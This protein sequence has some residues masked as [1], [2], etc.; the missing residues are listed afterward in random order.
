MITVT[1]MTR[2][3]VWTG[4][5]CAGGTRVCVIPD[6]D[7]C[8][9]SL[10]LAGDDRLTVTLPLTSAAR[11]ELTAGRVLRVVQDAATFD[12]WFLS[13][14]AAHVDDARV[15]VNALAPENA[16]ARAALVG[17]VDGLGVVRYDVEAV[18]LTPLQHLNGLLVPWLVAQ[19]ITWVTV[20]VV[21]P[22]APVDLS[23]QWEGAIAVARKI[24]SLSQSEFQFR[25]V[26]TASYAIDIL[27]K[28]G[29]AAPTA[30]F[31]RRKNIEDLGVTR[32]VVEQVTRVF[33]RGSQQ[34]GEYATMGEAEWQVTN[35][36]GGGTVISLADPIGGP[37]PIQF[38]DQL[39]DTYVWRSAGTHARV[40]DSDATAQT[41]TLAGA[42]GLAIGEIV[43]FRRDAGGTQLT[44]LDSPVDIAASG[45]APSGVVVGVLDV[46][47]VPAT[48]NIISNP[49]ARLWPG[50]LPSGWQLVGVPQI[51]KQLAA[52]YVQTA[53]VSIK[54]TAANDGIGVASPAALVFPAADRPYFSGFMSLWVV[55][56]S[57][58]VE[59]VALMADG[60]AIILPPAPNVATSTLVGQW[61]NLGISGEDFATLGVVTA[62]LRAVQDGEDA[63]VF[64][65]DAAQLTQTPSQQPFIEGSGGTRLWQAANERLRTYGAP[66]V[67]YESQVLDRARLDPA[68]YGDDSALV[69]GGNARVTDDRVLGAPVTTRVVAIER[70]YLNEGVGGFT[71][72]NKPEDLSGAS[73]RPRAVPRVPSVTPLVIDTH[74]REILSVEP[75]ESADGKQ[76]TYV[77]TCGA[78]VAHLYVHH[79][80]WREGTVGKIYDFSQ[81]QSLEDDPQL[82]IVPPDPADG[83]FR[84]TIDHPV[85]GF[86]VP[87]LMVPR[88]GLPSLAF[89]TDVFKDTLDPAPPS[90]NAKIHP[91][92]VGALASLSIDI[93][94]G[95]SDAD[96]TGVLVDVIEDALTTSTTIL[97][98][99]VTV[100]GTIDNLS[101]PALG[102][103]ALPPGKDSLA[104]R[105]R[106]TDVSG[107]PWW[108]GPASANRDPLPNGTPAVKNYRAAPAIVCPFDPDTDQIRYTAHDGR[109]KTYNGAA[110]LASGSPITYTVGNVLDDAST[111]QALAVDE[112]R[113]AAK[114]EYQGGGTWVEMWRGDLH[115]QPS[116][117]PTADIRTEK[118][119]DADAEN[120]FIRPDTQV[121]EKLFV[122]YREG[123]TDTALE[124]IAC[125]SAGDPTPLQVVA[126]T[127]LGPSN[128]FRRVDGVGSP[129]AKLSSI[130]LTRDQLE[131]HG[132][133]IE[134]VDS[135]I[136]SPWLDVVLSLKQQPWN[137]SLGLV[138]DPSNRE[139]S[140]I[141]VAGAHTG[142]AFFEFADNEALSAPSTASG[143]VA[144]GNTLIKKITLSA[145]QLGKKWWVGVTPLSGA[146]LSGLPGAKQKASVVVPAIFGDPKVTVTETPTTAT[147]TVQIDDPGGY[148][149]STWTNGVITTALSLEIRKLGVV[150]TEAP[151]SHTLVGT[152]HTWTKTFTLLD[153]VIG[154]KATLHL[155]DA[156]ALDIWESG[157]D[158]NKIS[159]VY[160]AAV[161][162]NGVTATVT[163]VFDTDTLIG[164][165][166]A[167]YRVDGGAWT[168]VTV[169]SSLVAQFNVTRTSAKQTVDIQ[170]KNAIDS[171]WGNQS[172]V[173]I[174]AYISDGPSLTVTPTPGDSSYSIAWSGVGT[175]T[176]SIDGGSYSTP[177]ASPITV[178]RDGHDHT[179]TF[180]A[181]QASQTITKT[182]EIPSLEVVGP[183]LSVNATPGSTT[184]SITWSGTGTITL[185]IDGGSF[186]TPSA[187]PITVTLDASVHVYTF[188]AIAN[189][190]EIRHSIE[191]PTVAGAQ[192]F[193]D[194]VW[195]SA[196][197]TTADTITMQW[198][199]RNAPGSETYDLL[200]SNDGGATVTTITGVTTPYVHNKTG[201]GGHGYDIVAGGTLTTLRYQ[202]A[203]KLSGVTIA[204]S[205]WVNVVVD[206]A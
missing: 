113:T 169:N 127:Q 152:L 88:L 174:D 194:N 37:A 187:S 69:L 142:S 137:E 112:T 14:D 197:S 198:T 3:E 64:Y 21:E 76:R 28:I 128:F 107:Q 22:T 35:V 184:W 185:S 140:A 2:L 182:V 32:S 30:D 24:A 188:K 25:R 205:A 145:A 115:G 100:P 105:V 166:C 42:I 101:D 181:V 89:G 97:S 138:F 146:G 186:L 136:Q 80:M 7:T 73:A 204:L 61:E 164:S 68:T 87:I 52:P 148:I 154:V 17:Q 191:I 71:L 44:Y 189:G 8:V 171:N 192:A 118:N 114:V 47:D 122:N 81:A 125:V 109:T 58:R 5:Q 60:S 49:A 121:D 135:G 139:L 16:L 120:V 163:V 155:I 151:T 55:S 86:K 90:P 180:K 74:R 20:G 51:A 94:F 172:T 38:D 126:G 141:L 23:I 10:T 67:S 77:V 54:V 84:F 161:A 108:F 143:D 26:G 85:R 34:D 160:T 9:A 62:Y 131:K 29:S 57:V 1:H 18:G 27:A 78:V 195:N 150:T 176:V 36:A 102:N 133:M 196:Q 19:A 45:G 59:I 75:D 104:W 124:W 202:V 70:D 190:Q 167:R 79:R 178:T 203:M 63:A 175:I 43:E 95:V 91:T 144:D 158:S 40:I 173:E 129:Q 206:H 157:I 93:A 177:A 82:T 4:L 53:G 162:N 117:P 183:S 103:R 46:S 168:T 193:V 149:D 12:E 201:T 6:A 66:I 132:A 130:P 170:G 41:V 96:A 31:R 134:G 99:R 98:K 92:R 156:S 39:N 50:T 165:N 106:I 123:S 33:P 153:H 199:T 11:P 83:K 116:N 200:W 159:D 72:S 48:R 110:L 65:V 111:E 13:E 147:M 119:A 179:Y 15:S 56:G